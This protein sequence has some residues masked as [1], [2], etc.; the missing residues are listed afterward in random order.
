MGFLPAIS[1][2]AVRELREE[3]RSWNLSSLGHL[4]QGQIAK[5]FNAK[6]Q[7]WINYYGCYYGSMLKEKVLRYLNRVLSQWAAEKFKRLHGSQRQ[8]RR[9]LQRIFLRDA[10]LWAHWKLGVGM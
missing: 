3:I 9:W 5:M 6:I 10:R 8:A 7:G 1:P 2:E 4:D